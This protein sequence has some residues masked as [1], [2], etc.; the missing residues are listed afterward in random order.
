VPA[1][2]GPGD[3]SAKS[4]CAPRVVQRAKAQ[5]ASVTPRGKI[6]AHGG[7]STAPRRGELAAIANVLRQQ[8]GAKPVQ[9][10]PVLKSSLQDVLGC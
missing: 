9:Y 10:R 1:R 7:A 5:P 8:A 6:A 2:A 4:D 3:Q